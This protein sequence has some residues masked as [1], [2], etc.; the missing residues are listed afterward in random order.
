MN[1][2]SNLIA[3]F[4]MITLVVALAACNS[5][6]KDGNTIDDTPT[7]QNDSTMNDSSKVD[8][9]Y[10]KAIAIKTRVYDEKIDSLNREISVLQYS[11]SDLSDRFKAYEEASKLWNIA[12]IIALIL[13]AIAFFIIFWMQKNATDDKKLK[14]SIL[15]SR[16]ITGLR[17]DIDDLKHNGEYSLQGGRKPSQSASNELSRKIQDLVKMELENYSK[18][19]EAQQNSRPNKISIG[20]ENGVQKEY[21]VG[22]VNDI[23]LMSPTPSRHEKSVFII[24]E[25]SSGKGTFDI[26][27]FAQVR[28][29]N[30]LDKIIE[31]I[32][33]GINIQNAEHVKTDKKGECEKEGDAWKVIQPVRIKI[34]KR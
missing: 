24:R 2:K 11:Y 25:T 1:I 9:A 7:T 14:D 13:S 26:L 5:G 20:Q 16:E 29:L 22:S 30:G 32:P 34:E 15:Q 19:I 17:N 21:Y 3:F 10:E 27:E 31:Y 12:V 33:S 18:K 23:Y 6:Q 28:Q 4:S 8:D